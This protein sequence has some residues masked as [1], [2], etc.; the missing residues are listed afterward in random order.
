[1]QK[2]NKLQKKF[3][4]IFFSNVPYV[5]NTHIHIYQK[6]KTHTH[7]HIYYSH[8]FISY[9][10]HMHGNWDTHKQTL[11]KHHSSISL[12]ALAQKVSHFSGNFFHFL[13]MQ[14]AS[15]F[16]TVNYNHTQ[17]RI[18]HNLNLYSLHTEEDI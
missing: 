8:G 17:G 12:I 9:K 6:K 11:I 16:I 18:I 10:F 1:M 2:N 5:I 13:E 4:L 15:P 14:S 3:S 7:T